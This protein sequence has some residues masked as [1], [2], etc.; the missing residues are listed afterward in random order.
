[1]SEAERLLVS[2]A[3][4]GDDGAFTQLVEAYQV[5]VYRLCYRMLGGNVH[6]AEDAAQETFLRAYKALRRYDS[7][8]S[9]ATWLLSIAAHHCIDITRK[10]R[11]RLVSLETFTG[12][13]LPD[14]NPLPEKVVFQ[15]E[16]QREVQALLSA[17]SPT[18][19]AAVVLYYW[20][21]Y[22]Y[23]E[24]AEA[25][26]LTVS[27]VK[28]RLHRARKRLAEAWQENRQEHPFRMEAQAHE[29]PAL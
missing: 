28:S 3:Q 6:D 5:P 27:A 7:K 19:R 29:S 4:Q 13:I 8:R 23:Q 25:L 16:R 14:S 11:M 15:N 21:D 22:S 20:Y 24:I 12:Q 2:R 17:L 26:S 9:F 1:M 10:R 18:D